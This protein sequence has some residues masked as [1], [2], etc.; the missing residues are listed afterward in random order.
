MQPAHGMGAVMT[1]SY[2]RKE[3]IGDSVLYLGDCADILPTL[4]TVDGLLTD[5]PY[6]IGEDGGKF[7]NRKGGNH[8][9]LAKKNWDNK[10][11]TANIFALMIYKS[12]AQIIWGGNY[13]TDKLPVSRGWLYWQKLMGGDFSDGELAWTSLDRVLREFTLC[14]KMHGKVHP[15]QKPIALMKWCIN[16]FPKG[17]E[18]I[19]DPF[20]GIGSTGV[21]CAKLGR[22]F[23]GIE[24]S[25]DY[26]D[27]ACERIQK[28]YDQPD[29]FVEPPKPQVQ[30]DMEI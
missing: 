28:A 15:T 26:F 1:V 30:E 27:I 19:L 7:R 9:I 5:P 22:K 6:G 14:N 20:M 21:A 12:K 18:T 25:E 11:P 24:L 29:L 10:V 16:H 3:I 4:P 17:T 13:F 8:R 2:S 23:I